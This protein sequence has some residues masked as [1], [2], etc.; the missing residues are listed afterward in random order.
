[1]LFRSGAVLRETAIADWYQLKNY[2]E[3]SNKY[4]LNTERDVSEDLNRHIEW[5]AATQIAYTPIV[6]IDGYELKAPYDIKQ[7]KYYL[8]HLMAI[9]ETAIEF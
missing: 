8:R 3:W 4:P 9:K 2:K 1:M 7:L 5:S 6:F